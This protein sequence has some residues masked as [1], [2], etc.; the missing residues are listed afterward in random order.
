MV[1]AKRKVLWPPLM[2]FLLSE[3]MRAH[4]LLFVSTLA[5]GAANQLLVEFDAA[6]LF[7]AAACPSDQMKHALQV[8]VKYP[9][10]HQ[11]A[12][13]RQQ[14]MLNALVHR[15]AFFGWKPLVT[16]RLRKWYGARSYND[17]FLWTTNAGDVELMC[18]PVMTKRCMWHS[19]DE[20]SYGTLSGL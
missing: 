11:E 14:N 7:L 10:H 20:N 16:F 19:G 9:D 5:I 3:Q 15:C 18:I 17:V 8:L 12:S 2:W 4:H 6:R 13:H 1:V